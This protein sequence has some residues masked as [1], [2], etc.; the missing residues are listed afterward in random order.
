MDKI[1]VS[2]GQGTLSENAAHTNDAFAEPA[3]VGHAVELTIAPPAG[4]AH[5]AFTLK[6]R[7]DEYPEG[8]AAVG[9]A[10]TEGG[11]Y[12]PGDTGLAIGAFS[13]PLT[14]WAKLL[15]VCTNP[16]IIGEYA[17]F[18]DLASV[19]GVASSTSA[20]VGDVAEVAPVAGTAAS[21]SSAVGAVTEGVDA[22]SVE[23]IAQSDS[24]AVGEV[25]VA[26]LTVEGVAQSTSAGVGQGY[27]VAPV[28]GVATSGS[29]GVG[30]ATGVTWP[31]VADF[32]AGASLP[33]KINT[34]VSGGGASA[35]VA[36]NMFTCTDDTALD[37]SGWA[38]NEAVSTARAETVV[39]RGKTASGGTN[40]LTLITLQDKATVPTAADVG[41]AYGPFI[42]FTT[43]TGIE[44]GYRDSAGTLYGYNF[45]TNQ[46]VAWDSKSDK[47]TTSNTY[48]RAEFESDGTQW[49]FVLKDSGGSVLNTF[50]WVTWANTKA[51][52]TGAY[53]Y[54]GGELSGSSYYGTI[55][56]SLI[57]RT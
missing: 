40:Y 46:W 44:A 24:S 1:I 56:Y 43:N 36:S 33:S 50:P 17:G 18:V 16:G 39:A 41:V 11:A 32:G 27:E 23:G 51:A 2:D 57:S 45:A 21:D 12:S 20:G 37:V 34:L 42:R 29:S 9:F 30:A 31:F 3:L 52:P 48:Y 14:A 8:E 49:R 15:G 55:D 25:T 54:C 6:A 10:L 4:K 5:P 53:W 47:S 38:I 28:A 19:A 22:P 26:A 13:A 35:S 7:S